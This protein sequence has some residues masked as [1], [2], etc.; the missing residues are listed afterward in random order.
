MRRAQLPRC[1]KPRLSLGIGAEPVQYAMSTAVPGRARF[2][3][4]SLP[5]PGQPQFRDPEGKGYAN[6]HRMRAV[7]TRP[8]LR[9]HRQHARFGRIL[10]PTELHQLAVLS[11][12]M[13]GRVG[14]VSTPV[15]QPGK[16]DP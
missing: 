15:D 2:V 14:V 10:L 7:G 16:D 4:K 5:H 1:R 13:L 8:L 12:A 11:S 6:C 3:L 9:L